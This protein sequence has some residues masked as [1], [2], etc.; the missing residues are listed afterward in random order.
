MATD[1]F[2]TGLASYAISSA[3]ASCIRHKPVMQPFLKCF[4]I[5]LLLHDARLWTGNPCNASGELLMCVIHPASLGSGTESPA[6]CDGKGRSLE[7]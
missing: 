5:L 6:P 1:A 4:T 3:A 7:E 2:T